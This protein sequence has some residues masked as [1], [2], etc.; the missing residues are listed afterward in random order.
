MTN[1]NN[2]NKKNSFGYMGKAEKIGKGV[3]DKI[4]DSLTGSVSATGWAEEGFKLGAKASSYISKSIK[5]GLS[6]SGKTAIKMVKSSKL[7]EETMKNIIK[8]GSK[9]ASALG[10]GGKF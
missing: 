10:L 7:G 5:D 3:K 6:K 9:A 4:K 2:E 1:N 8:V